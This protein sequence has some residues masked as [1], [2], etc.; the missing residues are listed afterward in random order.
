MQRFHI[1]PENPQKRLLMQ[2]VNIL[3]QGGIMAYPTDSAYALGSLLQ[4]ADGIE[5]ICRIRQIDKKHNFTLIC[6]NLSEIATY[7]N[8]DNTQFRFLK[9]YTPGAYTFILNGTKEVPKRLLHAKRKTIGIRIPD[10]KVVQELLDL[11]GQP[12]MSVT[13]LL[14]DKAIPLSDPD[15]IYDKLHKQID[16]LIDAGPCSLEPTTVVDWTDKDPVIARVGKADP[17][18]FM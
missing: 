13:L 12:L 18:P 17:S 1:H 2:A 11:L 15:E 8:V 9:A 10:S 14:P 16:A 5:R 3:Q 6:R 7:A 4:N